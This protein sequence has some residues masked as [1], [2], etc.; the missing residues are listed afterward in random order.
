MGT[1]SGM[2]S[3]LAMSH[4]TALLDARDRLG[5]PEERRPEVLARAHAAFGATALITTCNRVEMYV[6]ASVDASEFGAFLAAEVGASEKDVQ[7]AYRHRQGMEAVEHLLRVAVGLDSMV[8]GESEVLGQVRSALAAS[9]TA[10]V[11]DP[12]VTHIFHTAVRTGRR[13]RSETAIGTHA[14]SLSSI[15]VRELRD[16]L[17]G[18]EGRRALVVGAGEAS[19]LAAESLAAQGVAHIEIA[20][21]T[22]EHA[23]VLAEAVGGTALSLEALPE[24]LAR[25]DVVVS[26]A[27]APLV[28][29]ADVE[30]AIALREGAGVA[31]VD[32]GVP[33][34]VEA[35]VRTLPGVWYRDVDDLQ[36]I[37]E[38]NTQRRQDEVAAAEAI[39]A[40]DLRTFGQWAERRHITPV[41][42]NLTAAVEQLRQRQLARAFRG[43]GLTD[44]ERAHLE[45]L[46]DRFSRSLVKQLLHQPIAALQER[47]DRERYAEAV[48]VL[49]ALDDES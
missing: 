9:V 10:S 8:L 43:S 28:R 24:A 11:A 18:L 40:E 38:R 5:I 30:R 6:A 14:L 46:L 35:D 17:G 45:P 44:D 4:H 20:N 32:L 19:R 7:R 49:F 16:H 39:V 2:I 23:E 48:R 29:M 25:A 42:R 12:V 31:I 37:A 26:A 27:G 1:G 22:P 41:V 15:A 13:A 47:D 33:R 3:S 36:A 34:D 21:R